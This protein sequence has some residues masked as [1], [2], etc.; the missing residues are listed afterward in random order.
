[1]LRAPGVA[2]FEYAPGVGA[3]LFD[4]GAGLGSA[5]ADSI[6]ST[7]RLAIADAAAANEAMTLGQRSKDAVFGSGAD[8]DLNH[9]GTTT[10]TR[11]MNYDNVSGTGTINTNGFRVFI[12]G[13]L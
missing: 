8:G 1:S 5:A 4:S 2:L 13:T 7:A 6:S 10:L 3:V 11:D 12:K 9:S